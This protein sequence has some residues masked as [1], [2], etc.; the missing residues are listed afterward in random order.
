MPSGASEPMIP[1]LNDRAAMAAVRTLC[2]KQHQEDGGG[3][4]G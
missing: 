4:R 3:Q 2:S 1:K